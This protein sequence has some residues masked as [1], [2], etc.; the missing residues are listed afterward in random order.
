MP[1]ADAR[2]RL[3]ELFRTVVGSVNKTELSR[4]A[5]RHRM[6]LEHVEEA[7]GV[8][9]AADPTPLP[10]HCDGLKLLGTFRNFDGF[11]PAC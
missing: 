4:M 9:V 2:G 5:W 1:R 6:N 3:E 8:S 7:L 11:H 10:V